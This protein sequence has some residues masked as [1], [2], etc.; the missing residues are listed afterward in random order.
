MRTG[1]DKPKRKPRSAARRGGTARRARGRGRASEAEPDAEDKPDLVVRTASIQDFLELSDAE[2][3]VI[4]I[5]LVLFQAIKD[6]MRR[7]HLSRPALARRM[8]VPVSQI[9]DMEGGPTSIE[10]LVAVLIELGATQDE[11]FQTIGRA[12][13]R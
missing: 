12:T 6:A 13:S 3:A 7:K 10:F 5:E 4:E 1:N 8:K 11:V 2:M 9:I